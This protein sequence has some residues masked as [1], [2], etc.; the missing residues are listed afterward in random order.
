MP[1][2]KKHLYHIIVLVAGSLFMVACGSYNN[3]YVDDIYYNPK[4]EARKAAKEEAKRAELRS[5]A[6]IDTSKTDS[7]DFFYSDYNDYK[8]ADRIKKFHDE[9]YEGE[10]YENDAQWNTSINFGISPYGTSWSVGFGYGNWG[11]YPYGYN[12]Y[13]YSYYPYWDPWYYPYY[14]WGYPYYYPHHYYGHHHCWWG[15]P[16]Y[17]EHPIYPEY[18]SSSRGYQYGP[19]NSISSG[20]P[21]IINDGNNGSTR[22][23]NYVSNSNG[24]ERSSFNEPSSSVPMLHAAGARQKNGENSVQNRSNFGEVRN[25]EGAAANLN[26]AATRTENSVNVSKAT[27]VKK[28]NNDF[29]N[30]PAISRSAVSRNELKVP[31]YTRTRTEARNANRSGSSRSGYTPSYNRTATNVSRNSYNS[32]SSYGNTN[33]SENVRNYQSPSRTTSVGAKSRSYNTKTNSVSVTRSSS[34]SQTRQNNLSPTRNKSSY[35]RTSP[36]SGSSK[37]Y[38]APQR[39]STYS[40]P[41]RSSYSSPSRSSSS[42][43]PS[44]SSY[45]SPSKSSSGSSNNSSGSA[46]RK[47]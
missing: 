13:F 9:D 41:S 47:R 16:S 3:A 5:E 40:S 22:K 30:P 44:R 6:I 18:P 46:T 42:S 7:S 33:R 27:S 4:Y 20:S 29:R 24:I 23:T 39:Q 43:S 26:A 17:P 19:R 36:S 38:S 21:L 11:Y 15:Y 12:P 35:T 31:A 1:L 14:G 37:T 34:S 28:T 45:S 25:S 8:Y 2:M 10:Y 32:G